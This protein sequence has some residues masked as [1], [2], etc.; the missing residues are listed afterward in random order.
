M[1]TRLLKRLRKEAYEIYGIAE[2]VNDF[3]RC[4]YIVGKR[5][6]L[7]DYRK[8]VGSYVHFAFYIEAV[9]NLAIYRRNYIEGQVNR[10]RHEEREREVALRN[11]K[12]KKL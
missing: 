9:E 7:E 6:Y 11:K 2:I 4:E 1:K 8:Y 3:G 5:K 12:W 10:L